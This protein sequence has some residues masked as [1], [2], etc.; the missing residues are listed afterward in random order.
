IWVPENG[1]IPQTNNVNWLPEQT[2]QSQE[3]RDRTI[4]QRWGASAHARDAEKRSALE[5]DGGL[6][7]DPACLV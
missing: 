7:A 1:S 5:R 3:D 2:G 4:E 6:H